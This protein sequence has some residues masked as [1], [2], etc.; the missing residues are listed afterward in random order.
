MIP[1]H[2]VIVVFVNRWVDWKNHIASFYFVLLLMK[3]V[4]QYL[5]REHVMYG[6]GSQFS[7]TFD[8]ISSTCW[9]LL[10]ME[11]YMKAYTVSWLVS[12]CKMNVF[13]MSKGY[14]K[15]NVWMIL[16]CTIVRG[17]AFF[18]NWL[19][20]IWTQKVWFFHV[21]QRVRGLP[22]DRVTCISRG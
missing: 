19:A 22:C 20:L 9:W 18:Y 2:V 15:V 3:K 13:W 8:K 12:G 16:S 14:D 11:Y 17:S 4:F 6:F 1:S 21:V 10:M 5:S 7:L